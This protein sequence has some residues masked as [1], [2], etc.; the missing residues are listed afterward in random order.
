M[1]GI[2]D[3]MNGAG[4]IVFRDGLP[5]VFNGIDVP[6]GEPGEVLHDGRGSPL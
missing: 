4:M 2:G 6:P 5:A 3:R 1:V